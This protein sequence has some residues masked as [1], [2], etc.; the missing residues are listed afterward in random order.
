MIQEYFILAFKNLKHRG[1]RSWLTLIGIFIG[2]AAVVSLISLGNGLQLAVSSQF[3][4]SQTELISVQ[5]GGLSSF[6]PPGSGVVDPLTED[7]VKAIKE[8]SSVKRAVARHIESGK[9]EY[10][11][12]EVFG[13]ATNIPSGD[14]RQFIYDQ[15]GDETIAGRLLKDEDSKKVVLG[16]NFYVDKVGLDKEVIPGKKVLINNVSFEVIGVLDKKGSFIFDNAVFMNDKD[17]KDLFEIENEVDVIAVQAVDK[18]NLEKTKEDIEKLMRKRRNVKVGEENFEVSTPEASLESIKG[19]LGGVQAFIVIVASISIFIGAL[20]IVNT[21]TTS[22]L[23]RKKEIGI[24][25]A[26][27]ATNNQIFYQ[28]F[29]EAGLLGLIGGFVGAVFGTLLGVLGTIAI[30]NF[31][32]A[33]VGLN[34]KFGLIFFSLL[35]SFLIGAVAGIVPALNAS[36]QNPVEAIRG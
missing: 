8:L 4:V 32:G 25:K 9:L 21:M 6:G 29:I 19:I 13:Y 16:Y 33:E 35:G 12:K 36:K 31:I 22:V 17:I 28:F 7:D 3:G 24:M 5:A 14:D 27:G 20:G 2:V 30:N 15:L 34:I 10:N 23:E 18:D 11:N 26:I 1:V